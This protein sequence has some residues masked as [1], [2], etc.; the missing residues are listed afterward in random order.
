MP[1]Q[2]KATKR[3]KRL[4]SMANLAFIESDNA[5][6]TKPKS[7]LKKQLPKVSS[8]NSSKENRRSETLAQPKIN[9]NRIALLEVK[10]KHHEDEP[11]TS[12]SEK[13][14]RNPE[15]EQPVMSNL[16]QTFDLHE[17][18]D[19]DMDA[20][21]SGFNHNEA[22]QKSMIG[23]NGAS[24]IASSNDP[25][26]PLAT[27]T[28]D[29][30]DI[31]DLSEK[32]DGAADPLEEKA[33]IKKLEKIVIKLKNDK[34]RLMDLNFSLQEA[35]LEKPGE[36]K[37]LDVAGYPTSDWLLKLSITADNSDYIFVKELVVKLWPDGC[38][39]ATVSGR[40][41]NN[42]SGIGKGLQKEPTE[43]IQLDPE[44]V[45]YIKDRLFERRM[46]LKD[47]CHTAQS[48]T[49]LVPRHIARALANNP[50][51]RQK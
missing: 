35:L 15:F 30:I 29:E 44:K 18:L 5:D 32:L 39:H 37:F 47:K 43:V 38:G 51:L 40:K 24:E 45:N 23:S 25:G 19:D 21:P 26:K 3:S 13:L 10:S 6:I 36:V 34:A 20:G 33:K 28:D 9:S 41:S 1:K 14:Y 50:K 27:S 22:E 7:N 42:P 17:D 48:M 2:N 49:K 12:G 46:I 31:L 4:A 11:S 8:S 16:N